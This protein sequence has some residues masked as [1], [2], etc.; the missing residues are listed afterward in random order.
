M[1]TLFLTI[2]TE[3]LGQAISDLAAKLADIK[4]GTNTAPLHFETLIGNDNHPD[5]T[6]DEKIARLSAV[7]KE[8]AE[9]KDL[10]ESDAPSP[11]QLSEEAMIVLSSYEDA[12]ARPRLEVDHVIFGPNIPSALLTCAAT[13]ARGKMALVLKAITEDLD[14]P[15]ETFYNF[16]MAYLEIVGRAQMEQ[17]SDLFLVTTAISYLDAIV[18]NPDLAWN[19]Q[20]EVPVILVD[21]VL[22]PYLKQAEQR[23]RLH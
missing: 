9:T 8:L 13:V 20:I 22:T 18:E 5:I 21:H 10:I 23:V 12:T 4:S 19:G 2:T 14:P 1:S 16:F 3:S 17:E 7:Q 15:E 6:A 11:G